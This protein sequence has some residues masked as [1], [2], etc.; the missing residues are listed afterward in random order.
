M[1]NPSGSRVSVPGD[2]I[3]VAVLALTLCAATPALSQVTTQDCLDCHDDAGMRSDKGRLIGIVAKTFHAGQHGDLDCVDCHS[4]PGDYEDVPHFKKYTKVDCTS[5]HDDVRETFKGSVHDPLFAS[6]KMSCTSCHTIHPRGNGHTEPLYACGNCHEKEEVEYATSVHRLGRRQNGGAA[7]CGTCHGSHHI[8]AVADTTSPVNPRNVPKTCGGCHE[9]QAPLTKYF[10]RL[11]V[12]VP[13]YLASVHGEGWKEGK[14]TAV[15]TDCHGSHDSRL[16][17]DPKAHINRANVAS[18]CGHCHEKIATEYES[19]IHGR[20]VAV[21]IHDAPTCIDCH[22]EHLIKKPQDPT[23]A[24]NPENRAR[25]LCGDC[26]TNP[27][28]VSRYGIMPGVVESYLDSYHGWAMSRGSDL[29]A[30]CTDCHTV[31][32]IRSPLDSLSTVN[33]ANVVHTCQRCHPDATATF[34]QSYTHAAALEPRGPSAWVRKLYL[35]LIAVVLGGMGLHNA[36]IARYEMKRHFAHVRSE[37]YIQRWYRAETVQ[38]MVL[39][40]TFAGLAITGFAL[41]FPT[42]WW[43]RLIRLGGHEGV[44]ANLHR[45]FGVLLIVTAIY[46]SIWMLAARRGRSALRGMAPGAH[47][48]RHA[49]ENMA[50]HV[51]WR[52]SRPAFRTF[53]YTQKAEYWALVWGTWVMALTGLV[54]WFPTVATHLFP[55]W[56]VRVSE[57]VHFYEAIL[58][59]SAIFI[60]HFFFVIVLPVV[61]PMSTT[62]ITGRM[63]VHEWQEFHAGEYAEKGD[64]EIVATETP[65]A[66]AGSKHDGRK[67]SP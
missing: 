16:P 25:E 4:A 53:D 21:G 45:T 48:V 51:G 23:A 47:D 40:L 50:Y 31:H 49:F 36:L 61:Y 62:W 60:W 29:V 33:P 37:P 66:P 11:P 17:S 12:V 52:R 43:V 56:I 27:E 67:K 28:L 38:H 57:T 15:C 9:K 13:A 7:T 55:A 65:A 3:G 41:R 63:P 54:L 35:W 24:I 6:G 10:V 39:F 59:V 19:S 34:A 46:H 8:V 26:H 1:A 58:A 30:N 44:R 14:R 32:D 22:N 20:A 2:L 64:A 18:T 5:C 42:A